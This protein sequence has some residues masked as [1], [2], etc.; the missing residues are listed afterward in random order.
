MQ[1]YE[2]R[3]FINDILNIN[4]IMNDELNEASECIK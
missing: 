3:K 2:L 4:K 1:N